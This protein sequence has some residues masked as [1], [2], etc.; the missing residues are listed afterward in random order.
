MKDNKLTIRIQKPVSEVFKFTTNPENT[1]KWIDSIDKE[2]VSSV[3]VEVG[4]RYTNW[5][6]DGTENT[7]FVSEYE[8]DKVFQLDSSD[9]GYKVK[10]TYR[11]I[12]GNETELEY[13][14]WDKSGEPKNPFKQETMEKLKKIMEEEK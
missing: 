9:G 6:K 2:E 12:S 1:P 3:E 14:E 5:S 10:Y 11:L 13:L 4:T 7:Y 8:K